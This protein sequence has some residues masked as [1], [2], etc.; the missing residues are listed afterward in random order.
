VTSFTRDLK[1]SYGTREQFENL[2]STYRKIELNL[3]DFEMA[4]E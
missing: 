4:Q 1:G 2:L 3:V